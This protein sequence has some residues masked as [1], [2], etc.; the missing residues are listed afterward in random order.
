MNSVLETLKEDVLSDTPYSDLNGSTCIMDGMA[1][2]QNQDITQLGKWSNL[3]ITIA[4]GVV[5]RVLFYFVLGK[6]QNQRH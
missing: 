4:F 3:V 1:V 2:L 5:Y 6:A